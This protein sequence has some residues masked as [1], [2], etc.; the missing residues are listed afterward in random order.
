MRYIIGILIVCLWLTAC[1][2]G[3]NRMELTGT[4]KGLKKGTLLLQKIDDTLLITVDSLVI[5]GDPNFQFS[6]EVPSPE[7]FYLYLRLENGNLLDDRI[8]FFAEPSEIH[9]ETSLKKFGNDVKISGSTNQEKLEE[10]KLLMQRFSNR[11]LDLIQAEF[12]AR[13]K[14]N[15]SLAGQLKMQQEKML[16]SKY[17]ATVKYAVQQKK[18]EIAPYLMLSEVYDANLKYLDTVYKTLDPQVKESK[19]GK[20]LAAFIESRRK[21]EN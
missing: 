7:V 2:N 13:Q 5:N 16:A 18:H 12:E 4:V 15:D 20:E 11:N 17:L 6:E 1:S 3:G 21:E 19:Y 10:Y 9:I 8:P 14:G